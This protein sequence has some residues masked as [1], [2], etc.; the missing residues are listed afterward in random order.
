MPWRASTHAPAGEASHHAGGSQGGG[1]A[2]A[3]RHRCGRPP[4]GA[5]HVTPRHPRVWLPPLPPL[6]INHQPPSLPCIQPP[7]GAWYDAQSALGHRDIPCG[8]RIPKTLSCLDT[9]QRCLPEVFVAYADVLTDVYC[10]SLRVGRNNN[11]VCGIMQPDADAVAIILV[12]GE[13]DTARLGPA[14]SPRRC[15]GPWP[16]LTAAAGR[17]GP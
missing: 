6:L 2:Q 1:G 7:V 9:P 15:P 14:A 10:L 8:Q 11:S 17:A 3:H 16:C 13:M 5:P 12:H 4:Q